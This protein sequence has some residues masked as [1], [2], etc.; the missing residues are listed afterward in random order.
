MD[1]LSL[2]HLALT[3]SADDRLIGGVCGG[4]AARYR[5]DPVVVRFGAMALTLAA[6]VGIFLYVAAWLLMPNATNA[7]GTTPANGG[8]AR[9]G[10]HALP[11]SW[12]HPGLHYD[13][14]AALAVVIGIVL[15]LRSSGIW[16]S[17]VVGLIGGVAIIG[18][19]LVWGRSGQ[20][21][22][23]RISLQALRIA[24]GLTL[25]LIGSVAFA[26]LWSGPTELL[27]GALAALVVVAGGGLLVRPYITRL[28]RELTVER[29]ARVRSEEKAEIAS[30]LHD[31][32][33]QTLAIIQ[34]RAGDERLV[35]TLARRQERELRDWLFGD[36][37]DDDATVARAVRATVAEVEDAYGVRVEVVGVGDGSLD[38]RR[39]ALVAAIREAT[40]NAA[41][42][43]G[44]DTVDVFVEVT[45]TGIEAFVRDRGKG[46]DPALVGDD[47]HGLA[48]SIVSRMARVGGTARIRS[49]AEAGTEVSFTLP[50]EQP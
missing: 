25:I 4:I 45:A 2:P 47:R 33:L 32:V 5:L 18:V 6:G 11:P 48:D 41:R 19:G 17:D 26:S 34:Q 15:V 44:A 9:D 35:S 29:R 37:R 46:F 23:E 8:A 38:D 24:G 14:L 40:L 13:D 27:K 22:A 50:Q 21:T 30:H 1:R 36:A 39:Q 42:H 20:P 7:A 49:S 28:T 12:L 43:S 31:G 16:I 10:R 3:R